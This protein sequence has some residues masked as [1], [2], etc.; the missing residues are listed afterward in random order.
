MM[1]NIFEG[2]INQNSSKFIRIYL[3]IYWCNGN[4]D[5]ILFTADALFRIIPQ[6]FLFNQ[7]EYYQQQKPI[8]YLL[9]DWEFDWII[10][11]GRK[12]LF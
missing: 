4:D 10:Y 8:I 3:V 11:S 6:V 9:V 2:H 12:E 7:F 5:Y 1:S